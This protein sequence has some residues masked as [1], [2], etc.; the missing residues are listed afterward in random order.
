M[1][2]VINQAWSRIA[3]CE[4]N[5]LLAL[6]T[7][8]TIAAT[9]IKGKHQSMCFKAATIKGNRPISEESAYKYNSVKAERT[10][11]HIET[12]RGFPFRIHCHPCYKYNRLIG[13]L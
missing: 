8:N 7:N 11:R 9:T 10:P 3:H 6:F 4:L 5:A 1:I 12:G 2:N 13:G